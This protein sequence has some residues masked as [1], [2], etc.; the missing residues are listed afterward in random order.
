MCS[1]CA[2]DSIMFVLRVSEA[3]ENGKCFKTLAIPE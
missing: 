2:F 3:E 1:F